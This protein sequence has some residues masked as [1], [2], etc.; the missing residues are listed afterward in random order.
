[1]SEL[2]VR[3]RKRLREKEV[4][5]LSE[6]ISAK[7]GVAVFNVGDTVDQAESSDM[8]LVFVNGEVDGF[9]IEGKAFLTVRGL[10]K[11]PAT[12]SFVTVDM[13]AIRFVIN[14][15]DIMGPGIVE[16]DVNV[17]PGD[18]VWVRDEKNRKPLAVGQALVNGSE[19]AAKKPG[20][21]I[22]SILFVGDKLWKLDED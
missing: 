7:V 13:G 18:L 3:K 20:K 4:K 14:G 21:A 9:I 10:L 1:M 15:A 19:M 16:A 2:R 17:Q 22:K 5:A 6:E 12:R 11:Y 8:D